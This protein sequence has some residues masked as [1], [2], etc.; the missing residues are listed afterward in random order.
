MTWV[1]TLI[2]FRLKSVRLIMNCASYGKNSRLCTCSL[3]HRLNWT[4]SPRR[5]TTKRMLYK[6]CKDNAHQKVLEKWVIKPGGQ[7]GTGWRILVVT[8]KFT[9]SLQMLC[10]ILMTSFPP[11]LPL[12]CS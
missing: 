11:P 8:I 1:K 12:I 10:Y 5:K 6:K 3:P 9:D 2:N 7:E 4:C